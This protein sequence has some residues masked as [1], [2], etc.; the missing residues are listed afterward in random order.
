MIYTN[1]E[2]RFLANNIHCTGVSACWC[3]I[4]GDCI[5]DRD[6]SLKDE[7]CPLHSWNSNHAEGDLHEDAD[8]YVKTVWGTVVMYG[9]LQQ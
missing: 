8:L 9:D 4:H 3:P 5:C 6:E 7:D 2:K 1:L